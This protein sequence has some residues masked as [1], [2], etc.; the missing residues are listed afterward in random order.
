MA[1][2]RAL[3]IVNE[4]SYEPPDGDATLRAIAQGVTIQ[5]RDV[6]TMWGAAVWQ[7]VDDAHKRGFRIVLQDNDG[8]ADD[9]GYHDLDRRGRPYAMVFLDPI[10]QHSGHWLRGSN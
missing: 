2:T 1:A 10:L 6:A 8:T 7:V 9:D 4:S 5:L 3:K